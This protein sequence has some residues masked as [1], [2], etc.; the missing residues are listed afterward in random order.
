[1]LTGADA[2]RKATYDTIDVLRIDVRK[3]DGT[4]RLVASNTARFPGA[5]FKGREYAFDRDS[6]GMIFYNDEGTENGGLIFGG[7]ADGQGTVRGY[8]HLSSDQYQQDRVLAVTREEEGGKRSPG[9]SINDREKASLQPLLTERARMKDVSQAERDARRNELMHG[10]TS[11]SRG[12][13]GKGEDR[14]SRL[15]LKDAA[16]K[17]RLRL[18]VAAGGAASIELLAADGTVQQRMTP[19]QGADTPWRVPDWCRVRLRVEATRLIQMAASESPA[20][21]SSRAKRASDWKPD[22]S[23]RWG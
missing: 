7:R 3:A 19:G 17:T 12:F 9:L 2:L 14:A 8:G 11:A 15:D 5:I 21:L 16:G 23:L 1:M 4:L 13:I 6:A 22:H 20:G 18:Q 10:E